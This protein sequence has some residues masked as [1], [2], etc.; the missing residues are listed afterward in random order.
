MRP[1]S[2]ASLPVSTSSTGLLCL[3]VGAC[4]HYGRSD[5]E[6]SVR[7]LPCAFHIQYV[8]NLG[9]PGWVPTEDTQ[10]EVWV[11]AHLE[12]DL[13]HHV[14]TAGPQGRAIHS[15]TRGFSPWIPTCTRRLV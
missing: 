13:S 15:C 12:C 1:R 5:T 7:P 14:W 2:V 11:K 10:P 6:V 9:V 8:T 4:V 3:L